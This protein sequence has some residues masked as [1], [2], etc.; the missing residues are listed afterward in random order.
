MPFTSPS[1]KRDPLLTPREQYLR[2]G[3][4]DPARRESYRALFKAHLGEPLVDQ[5]RQAT[6][7]NHSLGNARFQEEIE[8]TLGRRA[9]RGDPGRPR[10]SST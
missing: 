8:A 5:I 4:S 6:N 9:K 3:R 10:R 7:G 1:L 2:L